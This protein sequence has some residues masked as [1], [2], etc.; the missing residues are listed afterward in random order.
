VAAGQTVALAKVTPFGG[1]LH[2]RLLVTMS[3]SA[4]SAA[5]LTLSLLSGACTIELAYSAKAGRWEAVVDKRTTIG[6]VRPDS[7]ATGF[8]LNPNASPQLEVFVDGSVV[9]LY[10]KGEVLTKIYGAAPGTKAA[11]VASDGD[12]KVTIG[13]YQMDDTAI[14][15]GPPPPPVP[16]PPPPPSG[17]CRFAANMQLFDPGSAHTKPPV[18]AADAKAC[19]GVCQADPDCFGAELYGEGCFVK[20]A[21]LPLVKQLPPPGVALV[22]CVRQH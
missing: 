7:P 10:F 5:T 19:C 6:D 2:M 18:A 12:A 11:V 15:G 21:K 3:P 4:S 17:G 16:V 22:A 13:A 14:T 9:E 8:N 1:R 20:T